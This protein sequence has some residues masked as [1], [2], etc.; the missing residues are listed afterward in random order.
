MT[1]RI[2]WARPE[3]GELFCAIAARGT[4]YVTHWRDLWLGE[5]Q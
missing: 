4:S 5:S 1:D 3:H 2:T